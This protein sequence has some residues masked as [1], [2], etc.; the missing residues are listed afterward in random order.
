MPFRVLSVNGGGMRGIYAA[1]YLESLEKAFASRRDVQALDI[2]KGF[3]L[4]VGTSTGAIIGCGLVQGIPPSEMVKLY[5]ENGAKIFPQKLPNK[6]GVDLFKQL[7]NRPKHLRQGEQALR[8]A[9]TEAFGDTT[10]KQVWDDRQIAL[11]VTAVK[12]S[13]YEPCVFKTPHNPDSTG[14]DN[15]CTLVDICLASSAA[16]LFRSLA[17]IDHKNHGTC[18]V[19]TDG[20]LWA[21]NPVIVAITESLRILKDQGRDDETVEVF[22]LGSCGKPEGNMIARDN[23]ARGL[24][25]WR[26]GGEAAQVSIA[27]Q[28]YAYDFIAQELT[29]YFRRSVTVVNFPAGRVHGDLLEYLDLDETR[30]VGLNAL[31]NKARDDAEKTNSFIR[32]DITYGPMITELFESMP[33]MQTRN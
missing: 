23:L 4:I 21:N 17:A 15:E 30:E 31:I 26:F 14:R 8:T 9:L 20:G 19:F 13:N 32:G 16:P 22:C 7:L 11:A 5:K 27:A 6:F 25:G 2:G 12:M 29:K 18:N 24:I 1:T 3:D 33:P 28:E 10:V